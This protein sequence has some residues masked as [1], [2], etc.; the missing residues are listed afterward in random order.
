MKKSLFTLRHL[1]QPSPPRSSAPL[2]MGEARLIHRLMTPQSSALLAS[3]NP[4]LT[5]PSPLEK[6]IKRLV[7][8]DTAYQSC[9]WYN[10]YTDRRGRRSLR[11]DDAL[12]VNLTKKKGT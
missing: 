4:D 2:P 3:G 5:P 6:V 11:F 1:I 10:I 9:L 8:C 12:Y 7:L